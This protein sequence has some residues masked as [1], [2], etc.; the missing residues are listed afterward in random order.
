MLARDDSSSYRSIG[1]AIGLTTKS[2][3]SRLDKMPTSRVI[4][5]FLAI[6]NP[7]I[8]DTTEHMLSRSGRAN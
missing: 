4:D 2:I 1:V 7:S 8:L 5:S 6:V 3:K